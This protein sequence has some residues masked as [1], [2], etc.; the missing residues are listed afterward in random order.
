[1]IKK[2]ISFIQIWIILSYDIIVSNSVLINKNLHINANKHLL[3]VD[4]LAQQWSSHLFIYDWLPW[5]CHVF[6]CV[7]KEIR[8]IIKGRC[9]LCLL[10]Y[11]I[12]VP[13]SRFAVS[14]I[15][16]LELFF[17]SRSI[18]IQDH[19]RIG[20]WWHY[21]YILCVTVSARLV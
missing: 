19:C 7:L 13:D 2:V 14:K 9:T 12:Y 20:H 21:G 8:F 5:N 11:Y 3:Y 18:K 1:M 16:A 10:C 15:V 17:L 4:N 6:Y